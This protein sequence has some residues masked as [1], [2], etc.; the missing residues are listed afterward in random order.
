MNFKYITAEKLITNILKRGIA[1]TGSISK[2]I[3]AKTK[4]RAEKS[5]EIRHAKRNRPLS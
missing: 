5:T 1:A 3:I 4:K 2:Y